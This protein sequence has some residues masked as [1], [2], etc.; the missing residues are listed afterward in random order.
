M[1]TSKTITY[2]DALFFPAALR[3]VET[4]TSSV[5]AMSFLFKTSYVGETRSKQ[6]REALKAAAA[7]GV[8]VLV[9]LN[10]SRFESDVAAENWVTAQ[11]LAAAGCHVKLGPR[12][13]TLHTKLLIVDLVHVFIGSHNLTR[14]A[15]SFN[16]ELTV[17]SNTLEMARR[18]S[19]YFNYV[20]YASTYFA[21]TPPP[22]PTYTPVTIRLESWT[23]V[24][25]AIEVTFTV[26]HTTGI[27]AFA[28]VSDDELHLQGATMG[29]TVTPE[30]RVARITPL[31]EAG[32]MVHVAVRAYTQGT[33]EAESN[34][35]SLVYQP[36][37]TPGGDGEGGGG[38][39]GDTPPE[40]L[41]A[42]T[43]TTVVPASPTEVTASWQFVGH[44]NFLRFEIQRRDIALIWVT[45][46]VVMDANARE[47]T[48]EAVGTIQDT[49]FRVVVFTTTESATSNV[50]ALTGSMP[51][52]APV[53]DSVQ[54][55]GATTVTAVWTF[56]TP[57]DFHRFEVQQRTNGTWQ[58]VA[59]IMDG[60]T[61]S[62]DGTPS[63]MDATHPIRLVAFN[64]TEQSAAS[65]EI[66]ITLL[67][68]IAAP[69]LTTLYRV[70]AMGLHVD[71]TVT[72]P[73][74]FARFELQQRQTDGV[75][76][77]AFA[78]I[79][80]PTTRTWEVDFVPFR[81]G[82]HPVRVV[83][84]DTYGQ[85]AASNE[86]SIGG[87]DAPTIESVATAS[88]TTVTMQWTWSGVDFQSYI[89]Q[90]QD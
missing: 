32:Q 61:R 45:L 44:A 50:V 27:D 31:V 72:T 68:A 66:A 59:T 33:V 15:L 35:A 84:F 21:N 76:W 58:V 24:G 11:D 69:V 86:V 37:E 83:V 9:V 39:G 14:G 22:D 42:P 55:S 6:F 17:Y 25:E 79:T 49:P 16:Y 19:D 57:V 67:S 41:T 75:T 13:K 10:Y 60:T 73:A 56:N 64:M 5:Q 18:A 87:P 47:W 85:S 80:S 70:G 52:A 30:T 4:A 90:Q 23:T 20:W 38:G 81:D 48:G 71:W 77:T 63:L 12:N 1:P 36:A 40:P 54:Q 65:N 46:G 89:V 43:L 29:A 62:W 26:N 82:T 88:G 51:V 28:A 7:R 8:K 34:I 53:L 74:S 2:P 3:A 78:T